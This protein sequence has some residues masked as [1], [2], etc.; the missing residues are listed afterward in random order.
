MLRVVETLV[1]CGLMGGPGTD[2]R[3]DGGP[4]GILLKVQR[5]GPDGRAV[6]EQVRLQPAR[7]AVVIIDMWDRHWCTTYTARVANM[8]PRMN[9]TLRAARKLGLSKQFFRA[10]LSKCFNGSRSGNNK[11]ES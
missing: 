9:R 3:A 7:T 6:V 8:V 4:Q 10:K 2:L 1:L 5:R 11:P